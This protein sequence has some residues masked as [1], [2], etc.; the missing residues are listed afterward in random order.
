[1]ARRDDFSADLI[2]HEDK[3]GT[4]GYLQTSDGLHPANEFPMY[5]PVT[6]ALT[7]S[8]VTPSGGGGTSGPYD[9]VAS[10]V[11]TP[12]DGQLVYLLAVVRTITL[13]ANLVGSWGWV[14]GNPSAS[15]VFDIK[16]N[17]TQIATATIST[18]GVFT[19][20][21]VGGV[22]KILNPNDKFTVYAPSPADATIRNIA[23]TIVGAR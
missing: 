2:R 20:S 21:T 14:E 16:N 11:G 18:S 9:I 17:G 15:F 8:G 1:M 4:G 23:M 22:N 13:P 10:Y 19:F 5:D 6:G 12:T 3:N 7:P